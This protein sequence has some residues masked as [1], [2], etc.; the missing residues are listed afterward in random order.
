MFEKGIVA[1]FRLPW[2]YQISGLE[3]VKEDR[4][5]ACKVSGK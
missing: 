5:I 1:V 4:V 2:S 3:L